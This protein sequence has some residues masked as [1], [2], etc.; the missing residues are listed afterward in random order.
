MT[1]RER[2]RSCLRVEM[3]AHLRVFEGGVLARHR[4]AVVVA[5]QVDVV[6]GCERLWMACSGL[7]HERHEKLRLGELLVLDSCCLELRHELAVS[8]VEVAVDRTFVPGEVD[9]VEVFLNDELHQR[10]D[11]LAPQA[12]VDHDGAE[13]AG[14]GAQ[15]TDAD[16]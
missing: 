12:E 2:T 16:M 3:Q 5:H 15:A 4:G 14:L 6:G 7:H 9:A 8:G 1:A 11:Q 13:R 10:R